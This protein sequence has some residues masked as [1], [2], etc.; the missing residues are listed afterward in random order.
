MWNLTLTY[1]IIWSIASN[2]TALDEII[3]A[4]RVADLHTRAFFSH[5]DIL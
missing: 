3:K 5:A 2:T 4:Y 1:Y